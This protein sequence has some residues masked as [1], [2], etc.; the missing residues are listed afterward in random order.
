[1]ST[2]GPCD[3]YGVIAFSPREVNR[4]VGAALGV[5]PWHVKVYAQ[6]TME[7]AHAMLFQFRKGRTSEEVAPDLVIHRKDIQNALDHPLLAPPTKPPEVWEL[8]RDKVEA[9]LGNSAP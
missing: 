4:G 5:R 9:H 1:M 6:T 7:D 3:F 8:V 2:E